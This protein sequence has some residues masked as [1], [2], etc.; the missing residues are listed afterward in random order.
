[1]YYRKQTTASEICQTLESKYLINDS[2]FDPKFIIIYY[3]YYLLKSRCAGLE[4]CLQG[5]R[6]ACCLYSQEFPHIAG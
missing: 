3:Y 6:R 2:S 1:M 5:V 4:T